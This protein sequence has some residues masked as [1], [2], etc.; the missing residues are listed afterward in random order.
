VDIGNIVITVSD[1]TGMDKTDMDKTGVKKCK[2]RH[3]GAA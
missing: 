2:W 3:S 1:K